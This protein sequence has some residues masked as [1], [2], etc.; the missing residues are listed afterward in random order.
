M[1]KYGGQKDEFY[2]EENNHDPKG[3]KS[4]RGT[5]SHERFEAKKQITKEVSNETVY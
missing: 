2:V 1:K 3:N 4:Y 5:K